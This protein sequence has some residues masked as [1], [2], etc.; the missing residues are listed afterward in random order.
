VNGRDGS[1]VETGKRNGCLR[2]RL[3]ADRG[4]GRNGAYRIKIMM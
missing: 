3:E 2:G 4:K 1:H